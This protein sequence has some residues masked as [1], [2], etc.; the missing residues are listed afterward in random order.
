MVELLSLPKLDDWYPLTNEKFM[1]KEPD[2][3]PTPDLSPLG[4]VVSAPSASDSI[5][6]EA[7]SVELFAPADEAGTNCESYGLATHQ[8]HAYAEA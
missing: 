6:P 5:V 8:R 1:V 7:F 3:D 2:E 4:K